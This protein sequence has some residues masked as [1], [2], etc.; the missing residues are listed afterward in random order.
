M[1]M[2]KIGFFAIVIIAIGAIVGILVMNKQSIEE[3][4]KLTVNISDYPVQVVK[5]EMQS[6][7]DVLSL[8]GTSNANT[9]VIFMSEVQGRVVS[10]N[11]DVGSKV[12]KG[13]VLA[14]V[15]DEIKQANVIT[16]EANLEKTKKD[17]DRY[18]TLV[19]QKSANEAQL[20][21]AKFAFRTAEAQLIIAK[22]Q[23]SDTKVISP[24]SGVVT[25][26][27]IE[28]GSFLNIGNP[29]ATIIDVNTL[30]IKVNVSEKDIVKL[31]VGNK[32]RVKTEVYPNENF[33]GTIK[34][35]NPK[36]DES[37]TY[38]VEVA[39]ANAGNKL[40][41]GMFFNVYFDNIIKGEALI[42]PRQ[43]LVGSTKDPKVFV[44]ENNKS[45]LKSIVISR[46]IGEKI[47]I[48]SGINAGDLIVINGQ[49]NLKNDSQVKII[50]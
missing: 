3:K 31:S 48:G 28:T 47:E 2:R 30:K 10:C 15:D 35:I 37:H 9:E 19:E 44:V 49:L 27:N 33:N 25:I 29:I 5:A 34:M 38:A 6:I 23:L 32:L 14:K 13:T 43:A 4:K 11:F 36:A 1:S 18:K 41:A 12:G 42:I 24:V 8:I 39:L 17:Y 46:M 20:D 7:N 26:K 50:N 21:Q 40:K 16:A 22:R 45:V